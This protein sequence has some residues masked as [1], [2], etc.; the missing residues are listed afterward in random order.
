MSRSAGHLPPIVLPTHPVQ[1]LALA[2]QMLQADVSMSRVRALTAASPLDIRRLKDSV[3]RDGPP[4][5]AATLISD[6]SSLLS[7]AHSMMFWHALKREVL[8]RPD[9]STIE[10]ILTAWRAYQHRAV[11]THNDKYYAVTLARA[12]YTYSAILEDPTLVASCS[13]CEAEFLLD[14]TREHQTCPLC[15]ATHVHVCRS[16]GVTY[17][18][19]ALAPSQGSGPMPQLCRRCVH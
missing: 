17:Q 13:N 6:R 5:T 11:K 3:G 8:R 9:V 2:E 1:Q 15:R 10:C 18:S 4:T 12:T 14:E 19:F 16:C 7:H